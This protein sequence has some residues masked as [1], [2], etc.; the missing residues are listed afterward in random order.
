MEKG[1]HDTKGVGQYYIFFTRENE[2]GEIEEDRQW[3]QKEIT[4]DLACLRLITEY[5]RRE[6]EKLEVKEASRP[7]S[8]FPKRATSR[9][10]KSKKHP[11][12][13]PPASQTRDETED[14]PSADPNLLYEN[15]LPHFPIVEGDKGKEE[16]EEI[17]HRKPVIVKIHSAVKSL[18]Q[19]SLETLAESLLDFEGFEY[20]PLWVKGSIFLYLSKRKMLTFEHFKVLLDENQTNLG[21]IAKPLTLQDLSAA[22]SVITSDYIRLIK[23]RCS[24]LERLIAPSTEIN[25]DSLA[26]L[27]QKCQKIVQLDLSN[28]ESITGKPMYTISNTL[29]NLKVTIDFVNSIRS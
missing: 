5:D 7:L 18:R 2:D 3:I 16:G 17:V 12:I 25:D 1:R 24:Q 15:I 21:L 26:Q 22:G 8:D 13:G 28:S 9:K 19:L 14:I 4:N 27:V 23:E 20:V 10:K 11:L 29:S 6:K